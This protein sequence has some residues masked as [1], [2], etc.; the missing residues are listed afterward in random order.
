MQ[1]KQYTAPRVEVITLDTQPLMV[2]STLGR[3]DDYTSGV[4]TGDAA[5]MRH[6]DWSDYEK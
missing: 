6:T 5:A 3:G 1:T 2:G 4:V